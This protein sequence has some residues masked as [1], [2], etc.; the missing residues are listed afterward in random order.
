MCMRLFQRTHKYVQ[1]AQRAAVVFALLICV[2]SSSTP[3][4]LSP[5]TSVWHD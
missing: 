5:P 4:M 2:H 3:E 1:L